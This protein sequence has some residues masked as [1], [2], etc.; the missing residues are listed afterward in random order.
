MTDMADQF[1]TRWQTATF[2]CTGCSRVQVFAFSPFL[3]PVYLYA[4]IGCIC[5]GGSWSRLGEIPEGS[6]PTTV[7]P[8]AT[9]AAPP[10]GGTA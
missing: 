6:D 4:P 9:N 7:D 10:A 2:L 3:D 8:A 1:G 5:G